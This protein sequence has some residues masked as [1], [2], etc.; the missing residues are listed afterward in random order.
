MS[1]ALALKLINP[2][3]Q[4][5]I[6]PSKEEKVKWGKEEKEEASE[7]DKKKRRQIRGGIWRTP[8]DCLEVA[9]WPHSRD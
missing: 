2:C 8:N 7:K 4:H 9:L 1:L 6:I 5:H 3:S